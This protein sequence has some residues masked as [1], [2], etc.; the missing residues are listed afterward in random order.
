MFIFTKFV[1][2]TCAFCVGAAVL[3][4]LGMMLAVRFGDI[5]VG[6]A[7]TRRSWLIL[8]GLVWLGSF[9]LAWHLLIVPHL[10]RSARG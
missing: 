3:L 8:W 2:L 1:A 9:Q 7:Y 6:I 5:I 10:A 4:D